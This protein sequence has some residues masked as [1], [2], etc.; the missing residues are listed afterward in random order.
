MKTLGLLFSGV[1]LGA[2]AYEVVQR[3]YP[4]KVEDVREKTKVMVNNFL[5][6]R[7]EE[8]EEETAE[9]ASA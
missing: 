6:S 4:G 8:S 2:L 9:E 7:D 1:F 5:R 3:S